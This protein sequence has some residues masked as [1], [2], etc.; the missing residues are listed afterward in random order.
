MAAM[1]ARARTAFYPVD[2]GGLRTLIDPKDTGVF[3]PPMLRRLAN[4]TGGRM[5][6]NTNDLGLAYA[7]AQ[8]DTGCTYT[9]GFYDRDPQPDRDRRVTLRVD[10][11][12]HRVMHS[13][14]YP[15][16][17]TLDQC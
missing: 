9:L 14:F 1:S 12:G 4:E 10:R 16:S 11:P 8:R 6:A 5:T 13:R 3:G 15:A 7:R 17:T 2:S